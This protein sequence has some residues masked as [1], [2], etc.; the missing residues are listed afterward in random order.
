MLSHP[1]IKSDLFGRPLQNVLV[2]DFFGGVQSVILTEHA[3]SLLVPSF[4]SEP[5]P[6]SSPSLGH[7][8]R[9]TLLE[10]RV[11]QKKLSDL[12]PLNFMVGIFIFTTLVAVSMY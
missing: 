5:S 11:F 9:N 12:V 3:Q 1:Q 6:K 7:G 10:N 2:T 8:Q 4:D